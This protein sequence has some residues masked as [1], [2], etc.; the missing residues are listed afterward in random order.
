MAGRSIKIDTSEQ[1]NRLNDIANMLGNALE[2]DVSKDVNIK[3]TKVAEKTAEAVAPEIQKGLE[4]STDEV[5]PVTHDVSNDVTFSGQEKL[6]EKAE[7]AI[8]RPIEKSKKRIKSQ[9]IVID[10]AVVLDQLKIKQKVQAAQDIII[11][12][13]DKVAN[14]MKSLNLKDIEN[15]GKALGE[16][17]QYQAKR[18]AGTEAFLKTLKR[19]VT[20]TVH[21]RYS[22][23]VRKS[24]GVISTDLDLSSLMEK[25][26]QTAS[27]QIEAVRN[28]LAA[29]ALA[30]KEAEA[31]MVSAGEK[32]KQAAKE[33]TAAVKESEQALNA[34]AEAA[35]KEAEATLQAAQAQ[36][37]ASLKKLQTNQQNTMEQWEAKS[38]ASYEREEEIL[39]SIY[40]LRTDNAKVQTR[41]AEQAE[42]ERRIAALQAEQRQLLE[43]RSAQYLNNV[44]AAEKLL[45][46]EQELAGKLEA[47]QR[48]SVVGDI[49]SQA[50]NIDKL[51]GRGKWTQ[52]YQSELQEIREEI[53]QITSEVPT[54]DTSEL[55]N[56]WEKV[57]EK[58]DETVGA[59]GLESNK[60][61]ALVS[62]EKLRTQIE[63]IQKQNSGMGRSFMSQ[64]DDLK[65]RIDT[66][67]SNADIA[68]L[69]SE[70]VSLEGELYKAGQAGRSFGDILRERVTGLNAQF[71]AQYFS[72]QDW[73][74]YAR[75][76][77]ESVRELDTALVDLK[78]TTS[79]T[80]TELNHFYFQANDIAQQTGV[81]TAEII[82]Q[83]SAWSRLGYSSREA[84]TE[85]AALSS[86]FA[87]I[88]PGMDVDKAT[89]GLVSTMKAKICLNVQ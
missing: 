37:E 60:M 75:S 6:A 39:R 86:Q 14:E 53:N 51:I 89:D 11:S 4:N 36:E 13:M 10:D 85:M 69:K 79:M 83:A 18:P 24:N 16:L 32:G 55:V 54:M 26:R 56:A 35:K 66:A 9:P 87:Q 78:K 68:A 44:Q 82:N 38:L 25:G 59:K 5:K 61:G 67:E 58:I 84:A 8:T 65:L 47:S 17:E 12:M 50:A 57:R 15:L 80:D 30:A 22:P 88:S 20:D 46:V 73:I 41:T 64:F 49:D 43:D 40:K 63:K 72:W 1:V 76:A 77:V 3:A 52:K 45:Q 23:D 28:A 81:T 29:E 62:L 34:Q 27:N 19:N 48:K 71:L 42:N 70:I 21:E 2:I 31:A 7:E 33:Q 74:R